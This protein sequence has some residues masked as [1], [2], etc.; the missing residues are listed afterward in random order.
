MKNFGIGLLTL[1]FFIIGGKSFAS[2]HYDADIKIDTATGTVSGKVAMKGDEEA[3][4]YIPG[5]YDLKLDG[6]PVVTRAAIV[7]MPL[8]DG[9]TH[10]LE[11]KKGADESDIFSENFISV[12]RL[13]PLPLTDSTV[14]KTFK[15]NLPADFQA[16][17]EAEK[18]HTEKGSGSGKTGSR[19]F[20]FEMSKPLNSFDIIASNN[21]IVKSAKVSGVDLYTY[22]FS[23]NASFA[24]AYLK[25]AAG[26]I[27]MYEDL[28]KSPFPYSR[29]SIVEHTFPYGYATPTYTVLGSQVLRLPFI[30]STSLGHEIV[31]QWFGC[32]IDGKNDG[33]WFEGIA[34]YFADMHY[35][36]DE[37][38]DAYRKNIMINYDIYHKDN[39]T[40]P[41]RSFAFNDSRLSQ[42][43]GYGKG[44][45][46]FH[47]LKE[48]FGQ[49]KFNQGIQKFI[50]NNLYKHAG[51]EDIFASFEGADLKNFADF[52]L[53][54]KEL[55]E[56]NV[57]QAEYIIEQGKP[58]IAFNMERK[59]GEDKMQVPFTLIYSS[60]E[61]KG[62]LISVKG[63]ESFK[64]PI[65][66]GAV[67]L[68]ID[69]N[70]DIMRKLMDEETPAVLNHLLE[71]EKVIA[72]S[73]D[74][75]SC[76]SFFDGLKNITAVKKASELTFSEAASNNLII[77]GYDNEVAK[78]LIGSEKAPEAGITEYFAFKNLRSPDKFAMVVSNPT[79][80]NAR[81]V[82]HYGKYSKLRFDGRKN[83]LKEISPSQSGIV[84]LSR[85][86]DLAVVPSAVK[87]LDEIVAEAKKYPAVFVGEKHDE[88]AHHVNQLEIIKKL[89]NSGVKIAVGFEM[90]QKQFQNVLDDFI[91]GKISEAEFLKKTEYFD[92]WSFDYNLYAPI[93][94]YLR[95]NKIDG[96][97]LNIDGA[98]NKKISSGNF[99][100]LTESDKAALPREM[101][102]INP[103][104]KNEIREIFSMHGIGD[105]FDKRFGDFFL[106]Q[107]VWDEVMAESAN[108]Y[109]KKNP[110]TVLVIIA[111]GGH[112]KKDS[113]I[114]LR[115]KRLAGRD[116]YVILQ[117]ENVNADKADAVIFTSRINAE[118]SPKLGV[119]LVENKGRI[120]VAQ[121]S[122][123]SPAEKAGILAEDKILKCGDTEITSVGDLKY[124]LFFAGYGADLKCLIEGKKDTRE[125]TVKLEKDNSGGKGRMEEMMKMMN[126]KP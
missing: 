19:L 121:V 60:G 81:L 20:V 64:V 26:Y 106:A 56:I 47:M 35:L 50:K 14:N 102:L 32:A 54:S 31:H 17:G 79:K 63:K 91:N 67:K 86:E 16:I 99:D 30:T 108:D 120:V 101:N 100:N 117:D 76:G 109:Q 41:L 8:M 112:L 84:V 45:M 43:I 12:S 80:E 52:W 6:R 69:R 90:I 15:V 22:F 57:S 126:K 66:T 77:C 34:A 114:P 29:F 48:K 89:K 40:Y 1:A 119:S 42:T 25:S 70:Y 4:L 11:Y 83:I 13:T 9:E 113:G 85:S 116:G 92:R 115:Y 2:I 71:A 18:I 51:W 5:F 68:V 36:N 78:G 65:K 37:E 88:Y 125:V 28:F 62:S 46:V 3:V 49:D 124:A 73:S 98:V 33:N 59:N 111:G 123:K 10:V 103:V 97:A 61:E 104:Y 93:F 118:E 72:V 87:T 7:N 27:K 38:K 74:N 82:N 75:N 122:E 21:F 107:N 94:R 95:E 110:D 96:I 55:P 53:N 105:K 44:A 39:K 23:E 58:F 24:E